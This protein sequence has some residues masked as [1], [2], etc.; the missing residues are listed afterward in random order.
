MLFFLATTDG[1]PTDATAVL[2][3]SYAGV[4][5]AACW[6]VGSGPSL[7]DSPVEHIA[8][9]PAVKIGI[10]FSGRGPDGTT[11]RIIPDIWTSFDPTSRFHR[12]IFLDPRITKF[13][14]ADKQKDLIPGTTIKACDCPATYFFRNETR[15]YGDF[16]DPKSGR[17]LNALDSF[18][19]ALD[20]GYRL[21][22]RRFFCVGADF[23]VRP[24]ESQAELAR[25][26]GVDYDHRGRVLVTKDTDPKLHYRSDRLSDFVDECVRRFGGKDRRAVI[27]ELESA[28]REQQYSFSET[29]PL[30]AAIHAD[31]HYWERVQ[32]LRLAR[33]N[34]SI[35]G[36]SLVSCSPNSRLSDWFPSR[37][38]LAV[39]DELRNACGDPRNERTV[40]RYSGDVKDAVRD[41]LPYHRDVSP[42]DWSRTASRRA[43]PIA[44]PDAAVAEDAVKPS[45]LAASVDRIQAAVNRFKGI[46][47]PVEIEEVL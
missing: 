15:G 35:H 37:D 11:P 26:R 44:E 19:Q 10:N 5:P 32:Y 23:I 24:S 45:P 27:E 40:G 36:V 2:E 17:I 13:L 12:S 41:S 39:C 33:R 42:Y 4:D 22:F 8:A 34:L 46:N 31:S 7:L 1:T 14:K 43:K 38:P 18:I 20:I 9:S 47:S 16:L 6:L 30:A 28:G 25:S 3:N 29:K 21:G